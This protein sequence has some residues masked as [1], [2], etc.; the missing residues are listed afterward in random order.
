MNAPE[1]PRID[2]FSLFSNGELGRYP[3]FN[4]GFFRLFRVVLV[5]VNPFREVI[6]IT[7]IEAGIFLLV[8][9]WYRFEIVL[10]LSH[11]RNKRQQQED[12]QYDSAVFHMANMAA[13]I[14]PMIR[15][16]APDC[17]ASL[18]QIIMMTGQGMMS[19]LLILPGN[20]ELCCVD[21]YSIG[22]SEF[23]ISGID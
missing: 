7:T 17:Y 12:G 5:L 11:S 22:R 10:L 4:S 8:S 20:R 2:E 1:N 15:A 19:G 14:V 21:S 23:C 16:D 13:I 3:A 6:G 9:H 18:S